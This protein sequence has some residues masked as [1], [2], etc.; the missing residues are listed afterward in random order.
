MVLLDIKQ[1]SVHIFLKFITNKRSKTHHYLQV[2]KNVLINA[3]IKVF[4]NKDI[5][6]IKKN[7]MTMFNFKLNVFT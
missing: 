1:V 3:K 2:T 7:K 5:R 4:E 6:M